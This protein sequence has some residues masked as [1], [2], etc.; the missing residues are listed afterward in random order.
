MCSSFVKSSGI[1]AGKV[2]GFQTNTYIVTNKYYGKTEKCLK[3]KKMQRNSKWHR[4]YHRVG[5]LRRRESFRWK[6]RGGVAFPPCFWLLCH[7]FHPLSLAINSLHDTLKPT[8]AEW[9]K[10][11]HSFRRHRFWFMPNQDE[12]AILRFRVRVVFRSL[13]SR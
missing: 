6:L 9:R 7:F 3:R 4:Q 5:E 13:N 12:D 8:R 10:K 1:S 11:W 2:T